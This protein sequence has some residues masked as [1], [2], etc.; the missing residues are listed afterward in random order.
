C[1]CR[2]MHASRA[3]TKAARRCPIS[4]STEKDRILSVPPIVSMAGSKD[5]TTLPPELTAARERF[6]E[7]VADLRPDLHRYCT[8]LVGSAIDGE[9]VVQETLAKAYYALS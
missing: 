5:M 9:D 8:R 6:L 1:T 7:M 2:R 3:R 4:S